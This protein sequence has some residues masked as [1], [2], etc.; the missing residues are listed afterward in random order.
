MPPPPNPAVGRCEHAASRD[1]RHTLSP[2]LPGRG[3]VR[4]VLYEKGFKLKLSGSDVYYT[5]Y[6][7]FHCYLKLTEVSLLLSDVPTL[8]FCL[9][10]QRLR[11]KGNASK[12][13]AV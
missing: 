9:G 7:I 10:E 1:P 12:E 6:F 11:S 8:E 5:N 4:Q 3:L 13:H 2:P